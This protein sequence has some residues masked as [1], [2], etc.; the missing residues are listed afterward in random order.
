MMTIVAEKVF[1]DK[2]SSSTTVFNSSETPEK[3]ISSSKNG[4]RGNS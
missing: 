1:I 2:T 4:P 3:R